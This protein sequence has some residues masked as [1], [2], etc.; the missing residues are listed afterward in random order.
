M[1]YVDE[2]LKKAKIVGESLMKE[3]GTLTTWEKI[4]SDHVLAIKPKLEFC[5]VR[6]AAE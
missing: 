4:A 1:A 2:R 3:D 5:F 6:D